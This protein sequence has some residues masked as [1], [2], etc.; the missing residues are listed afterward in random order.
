MLL[1]DASY[2]P[3][4][5]ALP[6]VE[7]VFDFRRELLVHPLKL[8]AWLRRFRNNDYDL[9]IAP[10]PTST[11]DRLAALFAPARYRLGFMTPN[12]WLPLSHAV[13][14]PANTNVHEAVK[15]MEL[16]RV[17]FPGERFEARLDIGLSR[18][19]HAAGRL[20]LAKALEGY[21][22]FPAAPVIGFFTEARFAKR[23]TAQWWQRWHQAM[24]SHSARLVQI[25]PPAEETPLAWGGTFYRS[26]NLRRLSAVLS[27]MDL[28]VSADTGIMHL[29]SAAHVPTV[30]LFK[31]SAIPIYRPFGPEDVAIDVRAMSPE[32]MADEIWERLSCH[33]ETS[34]PGANPQGQAIVSPN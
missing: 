11:S 4:F 32:G 12:Q 9:V 3:L 7:Q 21:R 26:A 31:A 8:L 18:E 1:G 10:S 20:A 2:A 23:L 19:E 25:L 34:Q 22:G 33:R 6:G 5:K 27:Q 15:A 30:G 24:R 17:M 14:P 28:F 16:L 29:A 13:P